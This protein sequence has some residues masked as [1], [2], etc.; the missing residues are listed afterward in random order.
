V[1]KQV[2][3]KAVGVP[4]PSRGLSSLTERPHQPRK[5]DPLPMS[6]PTTTH[7]H[8]P[9]EALDSPIGRTPR[10]SRS[11]S[12]RHSGS[13]RIERSAATALPAPRGGPTEA[14]LHSDISLEFRAPESI[15]TSSA[16]TKV[17]RGIEILVQCLHRYVEAHPERFQ[18]Q[19]TETPTCRI[20]TVTLNKE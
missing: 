8:V 12:R 20:K 4:N 1:V 15:D 7:P 19:E 9:T 13:H 5:R 6:E 11:G 2:P 10:P 14:F 17:P 16:E 3:D 18:I